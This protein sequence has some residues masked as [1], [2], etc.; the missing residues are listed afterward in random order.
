MQTWKVRLQWQALVRT[1]GVLIA[2]CDCWDLSEVPGERR[3]S[4][5]NDGVAERKE[6]LFH[7]VVV[8]DDRRRLVGK[9][10]Y[11]FPL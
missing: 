6:G 3:G 8:V 9:V 11:M 5:C 1:R 7:I 4:D 10:V 2:Q